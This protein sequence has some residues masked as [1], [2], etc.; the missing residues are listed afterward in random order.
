MKLKLTLIIA[1]ALILITGIILYAPKKVPAPQVQLTE[2]KQTTQA[3]DCSELET[4][5]NIKLPYICST[6]LKQNGSDIITIEF[7]KD[8]DVIAQRHNNPILTLYSYDTLEN[9]ISQNPNNLENQPEDPVDIKRMGDEVMLNPYGIILKDVTYDGYQDIGLLVNYG[10][11]NFDYEFFAYN[12]KTREFNI[13]PLFILTNPIFD[14]E[15]KTATSFSKGRG[16]ADMYTTEIYQ[17]NNGAYTPK[18][19]I[20]QD[21]TSDYDVTP[22][23]YERVTEEYR[24]GKW[25]IVKKQKITEDQVYSE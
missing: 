15:K 17:F 3:P 22:V 16:L 19:R 18:T 1:I 8:G 20:S 2:E 6:N 4:Q 12:P 25:V 24:D 14:T 13:E 9:G 21:I 7:T 5:T 10:A 23:L 11:Y